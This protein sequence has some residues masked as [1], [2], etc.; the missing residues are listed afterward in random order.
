MSR[1]QSYNRECHVYPGEFIALPEEEK[2][3]HELN[4][5]GKQPEG[6]PLVNL[7]EFNDCYRIEV[8]LPGIK[9]ENI[10]VHVK[11]HFIS[12]A[13]LHKDIGGVNQKMQI[14][15]FDCKCIER[16]LLLP[17]NAD[18]EFISAEF[19]HGILR[20]HI[21]KTQKEP[22]VHTHQVVVY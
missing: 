2:M 20:L 17:D 11:E 22:A 7:D 1:F 3:L 5:P 19:R 4:V 10:F 18:T 16:H 14:H 6:K 9:R 8:A 21:P 13:I 15:E 12:I